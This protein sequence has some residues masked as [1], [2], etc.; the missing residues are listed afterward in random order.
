MESM[1]ILH[2]SIS[3]YLIIFG[4]PIGT[5]GWYFS[6]TFLLTVLF[7]KATVDAILKQMTTLLFW[8]VSSGLIM[9]ATLKERFGTRAYTHTSLTPLPVEYARLCIGTSR[10]GPGFKPLPQVFCAGDMNHMRSGEATQYRIPDHCW[11]LEYARGI[12]LTF[13]VRRCC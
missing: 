6:F 10:C 2:V 3:E 8:M 13:V 12:N 1:W 4:S 5:E 9:L 7:T 11:A